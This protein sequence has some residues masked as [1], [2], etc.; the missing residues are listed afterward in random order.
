MKILHIPNKFDSLN[1]IAKTYNVSVESLENCN[2]ISSNMPLP[3]EIEIPLENTDFVVVNNF[4]RNF[5]YVYNGNDNLNNI[6]QNFKKLGFNVETDF[7]NEIDKILFS[8]K[9]QD[10]YVVGVTENL[11]SIC[12]KF[13]LN[14]QDV[15]AKN[16]LK[17][18]KL[19]IGQM[20]NL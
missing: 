19:F 7:N 8:K 1:S 20:L 16:N 17:S 6:K 5:L 3:K 2:G 10:I 4:K 14:K 11:E 13:S 18:E 9:T 15:I 12:K